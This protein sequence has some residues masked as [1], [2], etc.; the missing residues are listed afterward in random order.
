MER[1]TSQLLGEARDKVQFTGSVEARD[2]PGYLR[3]MDVGVAPY[4]ADGNAYF[5]PLKIFE[6]MA[7]SLPVVASRVG[8]IAELILP[9]KSGLL[10]PPG[11]SQALSEVL[12]QLAQDPAQCRELGANAKTMVQSRY[13]WSLVVSKIFRLAQDLNNR[14][15]PKVGLGVSPTITPS[16]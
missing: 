10:V 2:I 16:S 7:A 1:L 12:I 8:Q 3:K 9:G 15:N 14:T 13:T 4:P 6:Y 11:D 5:S